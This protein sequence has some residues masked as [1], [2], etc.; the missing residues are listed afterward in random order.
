[1]RS[2][3]SRDARERKVAAT[4]MQ[5][6]EGRKEGNVATGSDHNFANKMPKSRQIPQA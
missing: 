3:D 5:C 1:M 2:G 4:A 6:K